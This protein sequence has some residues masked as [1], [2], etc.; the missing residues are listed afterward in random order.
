MLSRRYALEMGP[1]V[2]ADYTLVRNTINIIRFDF[3]K[4]TFLVF[5]VFHKVNDITVSCLS[6]CGVMTWVQSYLC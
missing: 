2:C 6:E 5:L 1:S 4:K 3:E